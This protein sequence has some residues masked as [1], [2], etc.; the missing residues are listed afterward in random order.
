[1][2]EKKIFEDYQAAMKAR[3]TLKSSVLSF[4]RADVLNAAVAKN[5]R[6]LDDGEVVSVIKRHVKQRQD[7]IEQFEKGG[8]IDMA[9]K[10]RGEL[11]ILKSYLPAELS[12]EELKRIIDEAVQATGA[13]GLQSMGAVMKEV[14]AKCSGQADGKKVS[15]LV[16]QRLMN[17]PAA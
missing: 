11:V 12:D 9:Q 6:S 14:L 1:M 13:S 2:L 15:E 16:R 8:R 17:P 7:S 5:K 3:D 4:L 10:E